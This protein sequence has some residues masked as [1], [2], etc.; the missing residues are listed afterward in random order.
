MRLKFFVY[1]HTYPPAKLILVYELAGVKPNVSSSNV[2]FNERHCTVQT[3]SDSIIPF[4]SGF[5]SHNVQPH[6]NVGSCKL[7]TFLHSHSFP[8]VI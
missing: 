2:A 7:R 8:V 5:D 1:C 4:F 6:H 3:R